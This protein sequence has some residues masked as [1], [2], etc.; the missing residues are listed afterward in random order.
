MKENPE[1][2]GDLLE[3]RRAVYRPLRRGNALEDAVARLV[4][5]I[6]LGIVAPGESLPPERELA[7]SFGVSRDTVREAIREL[8]DT[9]YLLP[10]RG[11]YGGTFVADPLPQPSGRGAVDPAELDDVLGLRRVLETGAARAA[12]G[13]P[14]DAAIRADLWARHEAALPAGPDEYR[15]LDTLLHLAIAEAAGIPSLVALVAENR[16]AVNALLDTFPL[17]PRNIQHSG[18]QH[19]QI[20]TA[21]LAGRPDAAEAAMR[22]HLAGSEALL[23]GFLV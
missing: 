20:V 6:R 3:V 12:A 7:A 9:G 10:R 5:T 18:E 8:A 23:R 14:L 17:M 22:D 2:D 19:E 4:Q 16:A 1:G 15:R 11:R 13:R 21:I